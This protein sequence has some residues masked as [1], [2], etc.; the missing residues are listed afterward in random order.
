MLDIG[1]L[2]I[3]I[4]AM[5]I[6][7]MEMEVA[8]L[9]T[10]AKSKTQVLITLAAQ[11]LVLPLI[12]LL[13]VK[14]VALGPEVSAG[15]LVVAACPV[16]NI[17]NFY[18]LLARANLALSVVINTL[19]CLLSFASLSVIFFVYSRMLG[20]Q[21]NFETPALSSL[22]W[23]A[24]LVAVP[25]L[26]GIWLRRARPE[27]VGRHL[28]HLANICLAGLGVIIVF[29]LATQHE[30]LRAQW[31]QALISAALFMVLAALS[32]LALGSAFRLPAPDRFTMSTS[33]AVR[34]VGLAT[35][36]AVTLLNRVDYA[37]FATV[38]FIAEVPLALALVA[39]YRRWGNALVP[40]LL[41]TERAR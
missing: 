24:V 19:S 25:V 18:V 40:R 32:G 26:S 4:L 23:L 2:L 17:A 36:I 6:V 22:L 27:F 31:R 28:R 21:F 11:A 16:G 15:L 39:G 10:V 7:G 30:M 29:V 13:L 38:Y 8:Q 12:A 1:V 9:R 3:T 37:A 35:A 14:S 34:N 20:A 41:Q 5:I 33:F